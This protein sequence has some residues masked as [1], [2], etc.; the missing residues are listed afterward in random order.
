MDHMTFPGTAELI[1]IAVII[2]FLFGAR[3]LPEVAR[4]LS[5]SMKEL[6]K[7]LED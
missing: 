3:K 7:G 2:L 1:I 5:E 4:S 6:R